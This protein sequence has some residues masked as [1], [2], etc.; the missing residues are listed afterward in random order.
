MDLP[1]E[2]PKKPRLRCRNGGLLWGPRTSA[3]AEAQRRPVVRQKPKFPWGK[4]G[5]G[6]AKKTSKKLIYLVTYS[7]GSNFEDTKTTSLASKETFQL[8][9]SRCWFLSPERFPKKSDEPNF[10]CGKDLVGL[11]V[12]QHVMLCRGKIIFPNVCF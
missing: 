4:I 2:G 10:T 5:L 9:Q 8:F 7:F 12:T 6:F 3:F 1:S 11:L